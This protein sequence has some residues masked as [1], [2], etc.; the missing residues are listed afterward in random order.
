MTQARHLHGEHL[1]APDE[2]YAAQESPSPG[3]VSA[4]LDPGR[5][6]VLSDPGGVF[7]GLKILLGVATV[8]SISGLIAWGVYRYAVTSPR[9]AVSEITIEGAVR[10]TEARVREHA[11]I[12]LGENL[13]RL[14]PQAIERKLL[15]EPW[16]QEARV[17]RDL[18][19]ELSIELV[20]RE[21]QAVAVIGDALYLV[22]GEGLPF[23]KLQGNDPHDLPFVTGVEA[24]DLGHAGGRG[25]GHL[26]R[27][28][29]VLRHY[30]RIELSRSHPPQEVHVSR[31]GQVTLTVGKAGIALH[32]GD[33]PWPQKL[34]MAA[35]V[36]SKAQRQGAVPGIV[37]LDNRAHAERAVVRMR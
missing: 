13:F 35:R 11:G 28:L 31:S 15:E 4:Q 17:Q 14:D 12:K 18:P 5:S 9:F 30:R 19:D 7:T 10:L 34:L 2:Q 1:R 22:T 3:P 32:L 33:G 36:I 26:L 27:A 29:E 6:S 16:I 20:E 37:F 25:H 21:S 8:L 23:K 24:S